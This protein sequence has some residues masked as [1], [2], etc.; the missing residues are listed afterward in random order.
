MGSTKE[1]VIEVLGTPSRIYSFNTWQYGSATIDFDHNNEIKAYS[2]AELL[3]I[4]LVPNPKTNS[5]KQPSTLKSSKTTSY[6]NTSINGYGEISKTTGRPRTKPVK[7]YYRK[8]GT[9]VKPYYRS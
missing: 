4:R 6:S 1:E 2:N 5:I 7:G 9:Y 3:K 8:D